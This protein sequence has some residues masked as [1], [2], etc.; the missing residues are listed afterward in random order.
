M[1]LRESPYSSCVLGAMDSVLRHILFPS[2]WL[3]N[4]LLALQQ[5]TQ[6]KQEH[7]HGLPYALEA[8]GKGVVLVP[9]LLLSAPFSLLAFLLWLPLQAARRPFAYQHT[10][11]QAPPEPWVLPGP[12]KTFSVVSGNLCLLPVG[13][14]KFSNLSRTQW[15]AKH[16]GHALARAASGS[17][18]SHEPG[19]RGD[20]QI[21]FSPSAGRKYGSMEASPPRSGQGSPQ[22][23][24]DVMLEVP[25]EEEGAAAGSPAEITAHFPPYADVVCLQEVFDRQASGQVRHFLAPCY[26]HIIY[27]VGTLGVVGCSALKLLNSGLF[28][29][30]RYPVLAVQYHCY[31]NGTGEDAFSAKGLLCV[32]VQLGAS[33]GQRIVGYLNCT[34]MHAPEADNQVRCDQLTLSLL[35]AQQF[36][37]ANAQPGDIVAFNIYCGDLNFDNCSTGDAL[38]QVHEIFN[39]YTDPCRIG[40]RKDK[41]W[42]IGTLMNYLKIYSKAVS[43][44]KRMQRTLTEPK[45]RRKYLAGPITK[46]GTPDPSVTSSEGRRIDYIL[47][48]EHL[49]P[50]ELK[51]AVEKFFFITRLAT[52]SDH[53]PVGLQLRLTTQPEV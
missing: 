48:R 47:Y 34:H 10:P 31:P 25:L 14:A 20:F 42:A 13:L 41:P 29:A 3:V 39:V 21:G 22:L 17:P 52:F 38:E 9:L 23:S 44:P 4:Q 11:N 1:G 2:Y 18:P 8:A 15:R 45:G 5:T 28:L 33:Q 50:L 24:G 43:T 7:Q 46:D 30:S 36:Q 49:N 26:E 40:P 19:P 37:D 35:W 6:E 27:D 32:Q 51:T 53:L 12:A 16:I